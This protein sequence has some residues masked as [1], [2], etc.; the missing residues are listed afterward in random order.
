MPEEMNLSSN[1]EAFENAPQQFSAERLDQLFRIAEKDPCRQVTVPAD[2]INKIY[3]AYLGIWDVYKKQIAAA[4]LIK[5]Q[6]YPCSV[7]LRD[8]IAP[9]MDEHRRIQA[10]KEVDE[11]IAEMKREEAAAK[12][13]KPPADFH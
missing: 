11:A 5:G 4:T 8:A 9:I 7:A 2:T 12:N 3:M 10:E 1:D 6:W 13:S